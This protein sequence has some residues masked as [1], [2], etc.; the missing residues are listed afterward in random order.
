MRTGQFQERK[1]QVEDDSS[2]TVN[3]KIITTISQHLTSDYV[4][5]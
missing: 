3:I 5:C 1:G 4:N 2:N